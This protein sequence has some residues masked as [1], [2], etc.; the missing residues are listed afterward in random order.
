MF[1]GPL[2]LPRVFIWPTMVINLFILIGSVDLL[3]NN[4][5]RAIIFWTNINTGYG[6]YGWIKEQLF[7]IFCALLFVGLLM[8]SICHIIK[9]MK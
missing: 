6:K 9:K 7:F 4:Y 1:V 2:L 5:E 3:W 8:P